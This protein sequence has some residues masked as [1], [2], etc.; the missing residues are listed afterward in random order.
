M[1]Q[2]LT[3]HDAVEALA[4]GLAQTMA[5]T[6]IALHR[7]TGLPLEPLQQELLRLVPTGQNPAQAA[8]TLKFLRAVAATLLASTGR[9]GAA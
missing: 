5:V 7:Q 4:D 2:K 1:D 8:L 9:S 6:I 3:M